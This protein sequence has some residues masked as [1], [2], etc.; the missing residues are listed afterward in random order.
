M[1][2]WICFLVSVFL[3]TGV[4]CSS[5]P[6]VDS[7]PA[8]EIKPSEKSQQQSIQ[9]LKKQI[10]NG[11][12]QDNINLLMAARITYKGTEFEPEVEQILAQEFFRALKFSDSGLAFLRAAQST[13]GPDRRFKLCQQASKAFQAAKDWDRLKK[14][15][16]FCLSNFELSPEFSREL[17]FLKAQAMDQENLSPLERAKAYV[18]LMASGSGDLESQSRSRAL[19]LTEEMNRSQLESVISDSDFGFLRGHAAY[20][21]AQIAM[22]QQDTY[23]AKSAY[24]KVAQFLPETELAELSLQKIEQI[25][26]ASRVNPSTLGAVLPLSGKN[27]AFGQKVLRGLQMGLGLDGENYS[28]LRLAVVDS[29]GNPDLARKGVEKLVQEDNVIAVVG[30]MLSKTAN[31]VSD[32]AQVLNVPNIALSQKSGITN[33]GENIFRFAMTSEM[34]VRYL[35]ERCMQD[36]G[37]RRFAIIYPNDKF[38]VEYA[39]LFWDQVLARGGE[40]RAAQVYD[41]EEVDF[42]GPVQR[43]I[44]TYYLEER[45]EESRW[46]LKQKA[47]RKRV[48]NSREKTEQE[49]LPPAVDFDAVFIADGLKG[50]GQIS[51]MLA[52]SGVKGVKILGPSLW[53]NEATVKRVANTSNQILF[54]DGPMVDTKATSNIPFVK[55]YR[56][57]FNE[58]PSAFELQGYELGLLLNRILS[59]DVRSRSDF[60]SRLNSLKPFGGVA[61]TIGRIEGRE[62]GKQLLLY[63][64]DSIQIKPFELK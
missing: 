13:Q 23:V 9:Q 38:G 58:S 59:N 37:M 49:M 53:N 33:I 3:F 17:K 26:M 8:H 63:T 41:P 4:A 20:R 19:Q 6:E 14:G 1:K 25:E 24:S 2:K 21:L 52:Y 57:N 44:G 28:P 54:V 18:E 5:L 12:P 15:V 22:S 47:D 64:V 32:Q 29:E 42:S 45:Q 56:A 30:S 60:R 10:K 50:L 61:G 27:G 51:A 34:Q 36:L 39:N 16:E 7:T 40:I 46:I 55:Q 62:F 43:L 11:K 35:V 48:S 31:A